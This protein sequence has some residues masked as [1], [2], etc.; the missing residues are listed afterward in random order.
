MP[1]DVV[2]GSQVVV[3]LPVPD[4][5]VDQLAYDVGVTGVTGVLMC[6]DCHLNQ[7]A[8]ESGGVARRASRWH[9]PSGV[10]R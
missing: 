1:Q 10:E 3:A 9:A 4:V 5:D 8:T 2:P 7:D 6:L